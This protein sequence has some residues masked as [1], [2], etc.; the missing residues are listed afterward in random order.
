[1]DHQ[2]AFGQVH[3]RCQLL[4]YLEGMLGVGVEGC[5]VRVFIGWLSLWSWL[6]SK[7]FAQKGARGFPPEF[8]LQSRDKGFIHASKVNPVSA[9]LTHLV[10]NECMRFHENERKVV[11]F[12][13]PISWRQSVSHME[14]VLY[15]IQLSREGRGTTQYLRQ[16]AV[17]R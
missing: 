5:Q 13:M 1:M 16:V 2:Q 8:S 11:L 3:G 17:P 15:H 6:A 10:Y 7:E 14:R 12:R 4:E 9:I